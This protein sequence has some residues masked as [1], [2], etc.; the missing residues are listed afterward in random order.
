MALSDLKSRIADEINRT[1]LTSQINLAIRS[2]ITFYST[3]T[4]FFQQERVT[5][6]TTADQEYYALPVDF[7]TLNSL[8]ITINSNNNYLLRER[9][10]EFFEEIY[11]GPDVYTGNPQYWTIYDQQLRLSP[12]P[13]DSYPLTMNYVKR[14][15]SLGADTDTNRLIEDLEEQLIRAR[16]KWD[17]YENVIKDHTEAALMKAQEMEVKDQVKKKTGLYNSTTTITRYL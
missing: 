6:N 15:A 5:A 11:D 8:R 9:T 16:A 7:V 4:L 10:N 17:L 14:L 2:A 3:E 12:I 13:D 1:D